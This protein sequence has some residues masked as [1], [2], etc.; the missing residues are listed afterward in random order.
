MV[1][2]RVGTS[3]QSSIEGSNLGSVGGGAGMGRGADGVGT[4][5]R[6]S[7]GGFGTGSC[8]ATDGSTSCSGVGVSTR[9][10]SR[11]RFG[12]RWSCVAASSWA[13]CASRDAK[14]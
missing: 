4:G 11:S 1:S 8:L 9:V 5:G 14:D 12:K 6:S 7:R 10:A 3:S 13:S 2:I